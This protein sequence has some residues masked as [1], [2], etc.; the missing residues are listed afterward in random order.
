[1]PLHIILIVLLGGLVGY[2]FRRRLP[3]LGLLAVVLIVLVVAG[4]HGTGW[5]ILAASLL[6]PLVIA[7]LV[8][9]TFREWYGRF[10]AAAARKQT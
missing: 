5:L 9:A 3:L 8:G 4:A 10:R 2:R 6:T 1:V 7:A